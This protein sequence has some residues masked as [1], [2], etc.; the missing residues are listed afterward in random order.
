M[1]FGFLQVHVCHGEVCVEEVEEAVLRAGPGVPVHLRHLQ[2]QAEEVGSQ[3]DDEAGRV[4][5][6]LHREARRYVWKVG[7]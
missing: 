1:L 2:L 6:R 5:G 7:K 3:R 4:H